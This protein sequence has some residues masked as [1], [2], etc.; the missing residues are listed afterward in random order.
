[1]KASPMS[2]I[3]NLPVKDFVCAKPLDHEGFVSLERKGEISS[4]ETWP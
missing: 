1:M 4:R 2:V 3:K